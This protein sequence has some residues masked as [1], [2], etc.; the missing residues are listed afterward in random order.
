MSSDAVVSFFLAAG[1]LPSAAACI[2]IDAPE[3]NVPI[4]FEVARSIRML[5][6]SGSTSAGG[7]YPDIQRP[8]QGLSFAYWRGVHLATVWAFPAA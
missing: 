7:N 1:P 4:C 3:P 2:P 5:G 8:A 6:G